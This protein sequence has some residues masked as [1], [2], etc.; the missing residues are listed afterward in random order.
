M[1]RVRGQ[2]ELVSHISGTALPWEKAVVVVP[3]RA[4]R[5]CDAASRVPGAALPGDVQDATRCLHE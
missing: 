3:V 2:M 4:F 5:P 1:T